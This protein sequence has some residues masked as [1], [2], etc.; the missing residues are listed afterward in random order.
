MSLQCNKTA[1]IVQVLE[2]CGYSVHV[3]S[4]VCVEAHRPT[5][6]G[7]KYLKISPKRELFSAWDFDLNN[8]CLNPIVYSNHP[9]HTLKELRRCI[10][11]HN[12]LRLPN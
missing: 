4:E 1:L 9:Y 7:Y 10:T 6:N 3:S 11:T 8:D 2:G 12:R 5:I